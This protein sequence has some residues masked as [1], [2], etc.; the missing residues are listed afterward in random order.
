VSHSSDNNHFDAVVVGSGFGGSVMCYRLAKQGLRVCLLERGKAYPPGSFPRTPGL[1]ARNFW[2]PSEG[3]YGLFDV[4]S[5]RNIEGLVCSGLGGGSLI[6]ANVLLRKDPNWFRSE[7]G[8]QVVEWPVTRAQLDP[9]YDRVEEM[10]GV[11][12][13]P[14]DRPPYDQT[15]K[16]QAMQSAARRLNLAWQL[17][18]LAVTFGR[19]GEQPRPGEVI[20]NGSA[21]LHGRTRL[22]CVL[23]GECDIGCNHGSKNTLDF[24]YLSAAAREGADLRTLCEVRSFSRHEGG[25]AVRYVQHDLAREGTP[26]PTAGLP[27]IQITCRQLVLA[28]GTFG[29]T[30]L[31][32][33][34]RGEFPRIS[35]ALGSQFCGNGDLLT[36]AFGCRANSGG[37]A[38]PGAVQPSSAPVITS[39]IRIPDALDGGSGR[40]Y[41]IEDAGIPA[42]VAWLVEASDLSATAKR[43]VRF[44]WNRLRAWAGIPSSTQISGEIAALL[45]PGTFSEGALPLLGMGRDIPDGSMSLS[46]SGWLEN[47]WSLRSSMDYF[48]SLRATMKRLADEWQADF[49][50]SPLWDLR[51]VITVH[52]LGGCPMGDSERD[53]A[54][55]AYGEVFNYPGLFVADGSVMPGPVGANPSLTIAALADRFADRVLERHASGSVTTP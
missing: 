26:Y 15:A 47:D 9:H 29:T 34:N 1:M 24:T 21:N 28:A 27:L 49:R 45:G 41:Y 35:A 42:F 19:P 18:P 3:S 2:D 40:G 23:C 44:L 30:Y 37:G 12:P 10:I 36:F 54:V 31:L 5:F 55:N 51:R 38:R 39:A 17:P 53:G 20:E 16:T 46:R 32:L 11:H 52:P 6:Y 7:R 14:F 43:S 8:H 48:G 22:T 4:W 25:F 33:K 13:Y 50:D